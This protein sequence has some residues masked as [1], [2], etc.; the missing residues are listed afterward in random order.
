MTKKPTYA[1]RVQAEKLPVVTGIIYRATEVKTIGNDCT[2][3][4]A[5]VDRP[6]DTALCNLLPHCTKEKRLD[7][8]PGLRRDDHR[9]R[10][11]L[12]RALREC[13]RGR[14]PSRRA[15]RG[16]G[17]VQTRRLRRGDR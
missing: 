13:G 14:L 2:G 11:V 6:M 7:G 10:R 12:G 9:R 15:R 1:E 8:L 5:F 17:A 16:S 3:G 4:A